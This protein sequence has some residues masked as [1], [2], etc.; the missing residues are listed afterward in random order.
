M[1]AISLWEPWASLIRVGAKTWETRSWGTPYRG[2]LLICAAKKKDE[3]AKELFYTPV[4]QKP[5]IGTHPGLLD[6]YLPFECLNF[7]CAVAIVEL[8]DCKRTE[9]IRDEE[10]SGQLDF[11]N[12]AQ[13][14][15]GWKLKLIN[16][17]FVPFSVKGSQGFFEVEKV[18]ECGSCMEL[19]AKGEI[20]I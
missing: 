18:C 9:D 19:R 1:R 13:N 10:I 5:F 4:F 12:F 20:D 3:Q 16:G 2:P 8:V 11:G 17:S 15:F 6:G 7:G 14:R